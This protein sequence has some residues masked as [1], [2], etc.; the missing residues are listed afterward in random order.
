MT[1]RARLGLAVGALVALAAGSPAAA[2]PGLIAGTP[3]VGRVTVQAPVAGEG[4]GRTDYWI[5]SADTGV[6][7]SVA[8]HAQFAAA[9]QSVVD[10][11]GLGPPG[12]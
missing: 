8:G 9:L 4:A 6:H 2:A 11:N 12:S 10:Q 5:I 1:G 3:A 7:P